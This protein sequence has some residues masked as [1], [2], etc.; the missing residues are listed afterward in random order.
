MLRLRAGRT[1]KGS[2]DRAA[3]APD[4]GG[5]T[6]VGDTLEVLLD[7]RPAGDD[8]RGADGESLKGRE[9]RRLVPRREGV[10]RG[11][12][13]NMRQSLVLDVRHVDQAA[14]RGANLLE[15]RLVAG[16]DRADENELDREISGGEGQGYLVLPRLDPS[17]AEH[18][19]L[20]AD[21]EQAAAFLRIAVERVL[22]N[23]AV[24]D[25]DVAQTRNVSTQEP[26]FGVAV[27]HHQVSLSPRL[28]ARAEVGEPGP[29]G[30][31]ISRYVCQMPKLHGAHVAPTGPPVHRRRAQDKAARAVDRRHDQPP[32]RRAS[33]E[34]RPNVLERVDDVGAGLDRL[35]DRDDLGLDATPLQGADGLDL[36]RDVAA[37][38]VALPRV[39]NDD[40]AHQASTAA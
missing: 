6:E 35:V 23:A 19:R 36:L 25:L 17:D 32:G 2:H 34:Q 37:D 38:D 20:V 8:D 1:F 10:R 39:R 22:R 13:V 12:R 21:A 28:I 11:G 29:P 31:R 27:D 7:A 14:Q 16:Q 30:L 18:E 33:R 26:R 4:V 24:R 40:D 3:D 9:P 5:V 15:V